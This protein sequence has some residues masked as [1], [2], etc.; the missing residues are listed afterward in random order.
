MSWLVFKVKYEDTLRRLNVAVCGD[1]QLNL[2][3]EG[4]RLKVSSLFNLP[5]DFRLTYEDEDGDVVTLVDDDDLNDLLRQFLN[6][7]RIFVHLHSDQSAQSSSGRSAT[8]NPSPQNRHP[9]IHPDVAEAMESLPLPKPLNQNLKSSTPNSQQRPNPDVVKIMKS[10]HEP[11]AEALTKLSLDMSSK[12]ASTS[13]FLADL[14]DGLSK[15]GQVCVNAALS[16]SGNVSKSSSVEGDNDSEANS[17][18]KKQIN[19]G[20]PMQPTPQNTRSSNKMSSSTTKYRN[21]TPQKKGLDMSAQ[22]NDDTDTT[23]RMQT[24]PVNAQA[25][26]VCSRPIPYPSFWVDEGK[27]TSCESSSNKMSTSATKNRNVARNKICEQIHLSNRRFPNADSEFVVF[28]RGVRCDG[29]GV[30]PIAGPRFKSNVK[31]NF[32]LCSICFSRM[33]NDMDYTRID[34]PL[35]YSHP[36][37]LRASDAS[38]CPYMKRPYQVEHPRSR[39][40]SCFI[41][42][43]NV[44]DG[45]TMAPATPF[46]KIWRMRNNGKVPWNHGLKLLWV[47]GDRFSP[48]DSA[49]IH[50]PLNGVDVASELDIS[51]KFIAPDLPGRYISYWRMAE[52]SGHM[53]GQRVWVQI[54]VD[55]SLDLTRDS[56]PML[57]LNLPPESND[58]AF[59]Y[60]SNVKAEPGLSVEVG[61]C[62]APPIPEEDYSILPINNHSLGANDL[63]YSSYAAPSSVV[64]QASRTDSLVSH[65]APSSVSNPKVDANTY[66]A[67]QAS[68][69]LVSYPTVDVSSN[70]DDNGSCEQVSKKIEFVKLGIEEKMLK[71]LEQMGFE[72]AELNKEV[73][74]TN[75]YDLE[76]S[77]DD[78][79]DVSDWYPILKELQVMGFKDKELNKKLLVK[80]NGSITQVV[81]D[82]I[83]DD[84]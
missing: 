15:M 30:H 20:I 4:L 28:H 68:A 53:F 51:V 5:A 2:N 42:D 24:T 40:D 34:F 62:G 73:L 29:C 1:G 55:S 64:S 56:S 9:N 6:P 45:T 23:I 49:E 35:A 19:D 59:P 16:N 27:S 76:R 31:F 75:N 84:Q 57:N 33:G 10:V 12:A 25:N 82:L 13:P 79:C 39:F 66:H 18:D 41:M 46:I 11:L 43:V 50:V 47:G 78:L 21:I 37:S 3:M 69:P 38:S 74:R 22:K 58:T 65:E 81:I 61:E 77:V 32:D 14:F 83:A 48:S 26:G 60:V 54:Q 8:Q 71:E 67:P 72:Q 7:V 36:W 70:L 80:N 52:P 44:I 63:V 17:H